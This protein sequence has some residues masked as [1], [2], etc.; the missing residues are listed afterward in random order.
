MNCGGQVKFGEELWQR[1]S[2]SQGV[3]QPGLLLVAQ[4]RQ[5]DAQAFF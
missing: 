5:V 2:V 3:N 1:V 4:E